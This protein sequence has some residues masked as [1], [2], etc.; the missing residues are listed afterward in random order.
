MSGN[1]KTR[2]PGSDPK[3]TNNAG[4]PVFR[5][6]AKPKISP[7]SGAN[8]DYSGDPR[9]GESFVVVVSG[10]DRAR[11]TTFHHPIGVTELEDDVWV[12]TPTSEIP[13]L[14]A[15]REDPGAA[16]IRENRENHRFESAIVRGLLTRDDDGAV[17][18]PSGTDRQE[19][20]AAARA[21]AK[22]AAKA[23]GNKPAAMAYLAHLSAERRVEEDAV[24][25]HLSSDAV[26]RAAVRAFPDSAYRTRSGPLASR[27]QRAHPGLAAGLSRAAAE[28]AV[29]RILFG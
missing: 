4:A 21:A 24:R 27:V 11:M 12:S 23:A 29:N 7:L 9:V 26:M 18:Y 22:A 16:A 15:R 25:A 6:K 13:D 28:D 19:A 20:L 17:R 3:K 14:V 5:A 2:A 10:P 8:F 1:V